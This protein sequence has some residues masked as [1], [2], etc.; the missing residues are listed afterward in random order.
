MTGDNDNNAN[1]NGGG[2]DYGLA[3]FTT[4][5]P[6]QYHRGHALTIYD[7][8]LMHDGGRVLFQ[9][10]D[11]T[12]PHGSIT[13]LVGTNGAGKS[14]FAQVLASKALDGFPND[15]VVEYLAAADDED[16]HYQSDSLE[17]R[18]REFI[19]SRLQ[20]RL[21][22]LRKIIEDMEQLLEEADEEVGEK[23]AEELSDTYEAEE[24]MVER[25][26]RETDLAM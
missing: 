16:N 3:T 23:T 12:L 14:S 11:C 7:L 9:A 1:D 15:L 26:E 19:Q 20:V 25:L 17:K 18:P 2:P 6:C 4:S 24:A 10:G 5:A 8:S 13:G 21:D 22:H